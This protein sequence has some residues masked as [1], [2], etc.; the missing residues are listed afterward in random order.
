MTD[1]DMRSH[2]ETAE[3]TAGFQVGRRTVGGALAITAGAMIALSAVVPWIAGSDSGR[4]AYG[5]NI[6]ASGAGTVG[7]RA[8][9][10]GGDGLVFVLVGVVA[11]LVGA[12]TLAGTQRRWD[13]PALAVGAVLTALWT[14]ADVAQIGA[15]PGPDGSTLDLHIGFG[16]IIVLLGA[17][18]AATAA[19]MIPRDLGQRTLRSALILERRLYWTGHY[20][21]SLEILQRNFQLALRHADDESF[22]VGDLE[23]MLS[24]VCRNQANVGRY[25]QARQNC[26]LLID[27]IEH[28]YQDDP[29]ELTVRRLDVADALLWFDIGY[30][31]TYVEWLWGDAVRRFGQDA[32]ALTWTSDR[33]NEVRAEISSIVN[34]RPA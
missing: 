5:I 25:E 2:V 29:I 13:R 9:W 14:W 15:I 12:M 19:T 1:V 8:G 31:S 34:S 18:L 30:A 20:R 26:R 6:A 3:Q 23:R 33:C 10:A 21:D 28:R 17:V 16:P 11:G 7:S 24:N 32:Q 27:W 22:E 4:V